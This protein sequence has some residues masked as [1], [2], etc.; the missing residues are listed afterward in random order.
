MKENNSLIDKYSIERTIG[1]GAFAKVKLAKHIRSNEKCAIKIYKKS[2]IKNN[3][4]SK[5]I[6]ELK[7]IKNLNHINLIK[8]FEV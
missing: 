8:V 6:E 1:I 4:L 3:D 7:V 5:I 2:K